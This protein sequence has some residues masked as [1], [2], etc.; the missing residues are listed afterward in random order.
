MRIVY[1]GNHNNGYNILEFLLLSKENVVCI[2]V[3]ADAD[4]P[5]PYKSVKELALSHNL[6]I[7]QTKNVNQHYDE[8]KGYTPD[9]IFSINFG[10]ILRSPLIEL[11]SMGCINLHTSLLPK[12][13]G[14]H[15]NIW[16]IVNGEKETGVTFHYI[17]ERIDDGEILGLS[18]IPIELW[19]TGKTLY[20]KMSKK[21]L[22]LFKELYPKI[23]SGDIKPIPQDNSNATIHRK[24]DLKKID[25]IDIDTLSGR[26]LYNI[27]RART[28]PPYDGCY[29]KAGCKRIYLKLEIDVRESSGG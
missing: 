8:I 23:K 5:H 6:P 27:L 4:E 13:R 22:E 18:P 15:P 10:Q 17:T 16:A 1:M 14:S 28:F 25:E 21:A 24:K 7:I 20:E 11:P 9:I 19:D 2:V 12:N 26:K 3:H 29:I